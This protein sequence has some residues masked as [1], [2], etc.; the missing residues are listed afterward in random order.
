VE[1]FPECS[2]CLQDKCNWVLGQLP[3]RRGIS[4]S[5]YIWKRDEAAE[6]A[7]IRE[8]LGLGITN[9]VANCRLSGA[10]QESIERMKYIQSG[11]E[12][13]AMSSEGK[14]SPQ[15]LDRVYGPA[16]SVEAAAPCLAD[17]TR[18]AAT[19]RSGHEPDQSFRENSS[20]QLCGK[21]LVSILRR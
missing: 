5:R 20:G 10:P 13:A 19:A 17:C 11:G 16:A 1:T 14:L 15:G 2:I 8:Q 9:K 21:D 12:L 18:I 4:D 7:I 3:L 6:L